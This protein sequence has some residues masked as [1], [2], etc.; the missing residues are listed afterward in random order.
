MVAFLVKNRERK[1]GEALITSKIREGILKGSGGAD[2]D[3]G[4]GAPGGPDEGRTGDLLENRSTKA[5]GHYTR[6]L[7]DLVSPLKDLKA[8]HVREGNFLLQILPTELRGG[9]PLVL[10]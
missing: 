6:D 7:L 8:P 3:A 10:S 4:E 2:Q 5:N 9:N 1:K